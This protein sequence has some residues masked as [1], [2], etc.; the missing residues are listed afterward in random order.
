M[1]AKIRKEIDLFHTLSYICFKVFCLRPNRGKINVWWWNQRKEK[2]RGFLMIS[3]RIQEILKYQAIMD[4]LFLNLLM[5]LSLKVEFSWVY[6]PEVFHLPPLNTK[7]EYFLLV[8]TKQGYFQLSVTSSS[9]WPWYSPHSPSQ[10]QKNP[11]Y[12]NY[13]AILFPDIL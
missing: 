2:E 7:H 6:K 12:Q 10:H 5:L 13:Y 9:L 4:Y 11:N 3:R 8:R 1:K